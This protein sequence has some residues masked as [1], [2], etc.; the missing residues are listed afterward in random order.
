[1]ARSTA[2]RSGFRRRKVTEMAAELGFARVTLRL[3]GGQ[4]YLLLLRKRVSG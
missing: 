1:M 3:V 4:R 2:N